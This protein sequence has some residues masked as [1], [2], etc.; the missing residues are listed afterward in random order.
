VKEV[1]AGKLKGVRILGR[2]FSNDA[3]PSRLEHEEIRPGGTA[4]DGR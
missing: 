1:L 4:G 3:Q 2:P